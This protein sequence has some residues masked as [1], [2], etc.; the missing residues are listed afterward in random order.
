[1]SSI[2]REHGAPKIACKVGIDL[3]M[4][5]IKRHVFHI[6]TT[7]TP[8]TTVPLIV[9]PTGIYLIHE[10]DNHFTCGKS[11]PDDPVGFDFEF[12]RQVFIDNLWEDL[13]TY[14]PDMADLKVN[15]GWTG[16]YA[17][18]TMDGNALLGELSTV[19]GFLFA[20]GFSGHGFQQCH[21]V[22]RYLAE[23]IRGVAYSLDLSIFSPERI[24]TNTPVFED[25]HKLV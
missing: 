15:G 10:R 5:A 11:L 22:G 4:Q 9:F 12:N 23:I 19:K 16:L 18:N 17:V 14:M 3:P 24:L 7:I 20:N 25:P 8:D 21:A 2:V 1:M 6:E 13:V